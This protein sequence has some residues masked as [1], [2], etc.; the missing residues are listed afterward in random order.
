MR[1]VCVTVCSCFA[2]QEPPRPP[3]DTWA[4]GMVPLV[5]VEGVESQ[6]RSES[7]VTSRHSKYVSGVGLD[8]GCVFHM[9]PCCIRTYVCMSVCPHVS[10]TCHVN[11]SVCL[12]L[13]LCLHV[14]VCM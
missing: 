13:C 5:Q 2:P 12:S 10:H 7:R 11:T 1:L 6:G 4:R 3:V 8:E 9:S 14:F